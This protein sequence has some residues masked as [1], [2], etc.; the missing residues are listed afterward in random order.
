MAEERIDL[1]SQSGNPF[2]ISK[3]T[4]LFRFH[5]CRLHCLN[6]MSGESYGEFGRRQCDL[7]G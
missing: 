5:G 2:A 3:A 1:V 7:I 6:D 4:S